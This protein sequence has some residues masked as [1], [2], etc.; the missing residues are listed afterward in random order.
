[1]ARCV[2]NWQ[3]VGLRVCCLISAAQLGELFGDWD[4][5]PQIRLLPRNNRC[6]SKHWHAMG[7][8]TE[9][10][11]SVRILSGGGVRNRGGLNWLLPYCCAACKRLKVFHGL[12]KPKKRRQCDQCQCCRPP[13]LAAAECSFKYSQITKCHN[14]CLAC[15]IFRVLKS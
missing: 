12:S 7:I 4:P 13:L 15:L 2:W 8:R 6:K 9:A 10:A 3:L 11:L 14:L 5:Q 1:M